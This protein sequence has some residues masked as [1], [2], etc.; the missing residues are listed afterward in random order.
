MGLGTLVGLRGG[1]HW[2]R[3]ACAV[4]LLG[5]AT[6]RDTALAGGY[7]SQPSSRP[8]T[9]PAD[10]EGY[11]LRVVADPVNIRSR[12][13][14][15]SL[16]VTRVPRETVLRALDS[17]F[18]WHRILPPEGTFSLVA[19][20]Y[21]DVR[22][23]TEGR[24]AVREGGLRVRVGSTL[25]E[26]NPLDTEVQATL[27]RDT[28]VQIV[29]R[30]GEW[31]KIAP[32]TGVY[33]YVSDQ[34]VARV[35]AD[36]AERLRGQT[37]ARKGEA[38]AEPTGRETARQEPRSPAET[39]PARA[40]PD[41]SGPWGERLVL[42]EAA[43]QE[44]ARRAPLEQRWEGLIGQLRPLA[45]QR[46]DATVA[47]LAEAWIRQLRDRIADIETLRAT[48]EVA[49]QGARERALRER[50]LERIERV[51]NQPATQP[52]YTAR[53]ELLRSVVAVERGGRRLYKLQDPLTRRV[54]VYLEFDP[55]AG[56][57][58][59]AYL[60][61][62]IAVRGTRRPDREL[63]ADLVRVEALMSQSP[64]GPTTRPAEPASRP[65]APGRP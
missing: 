40:E 52:D 12:P 26:V 35:S 34:H 64:A 59:E 18:G 45:E 7:Q 19:A 56:I 58:P 32:P 39:Q 1:L 55:Q 29:G 24:V 20:A 61:Q 22:S 62:Y 60:G 10:G 28:P 16:A 14:A 5:P 4:A 38:P 50:E 21:V 37:E 2:Y 25:R 47:R 65:A 48:T 30:Q 33:F 11:W 63:G 17:E 6:S 42:L 46:E 43:I 31:L 41:L 3:L 54:E 9:A 49:R 8:A 23:E 44:E 57:D 15:N 13:D 27:E 51:R 36:I 53:G